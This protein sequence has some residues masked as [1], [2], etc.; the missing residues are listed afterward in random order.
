MYRCNLGESRALGD[1]K[2]QANL[3][4]PYEIVGSR[5]IRLG[6]RESSNDLAVVFPMI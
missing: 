5:L 6:G 1:G 3:A 4:G 2:G